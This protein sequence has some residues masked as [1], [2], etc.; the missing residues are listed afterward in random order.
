LN[1]LNL[2][3]NILDH[4]GLQEYVVNCISMDA[5]QSLYDDIETEGGS[6]FI[7]SRAIDVYKRRPLSKNTHYMLTSKEAKQLKDDSRIASIQNANLIRAS[8]RMASYTQTATFSKTPPSSPIT[9]DYKNWGLVRSI[10]G[11]KT[12]GWGDDASYTRT[13]TI[14]LNDTGKNV[15]VIIVDGISPVPNHPEFAK[16][17][18]GTGGT[19]YVQYDWY[20]LNSIVG[21]YPA[22]TSYYSYDDSY[23]PKSQLYKNH[24]THVAG[25]VAGNTNGWARDANIYQIS[26]YGFG[27]IDPLLIWDYIRAFH[28]NKTVNPLTGR[29]NP[30]ICNCSYEYTFTSEY[31][32]NGGFGKPIFAQ[33]RDVGIGELIVVDEIPQGIAGRELSQDEL[34]RLGIIN[35]PYSNYDVVPPEIGSP[36]FEFPF[37]NEEIAS[38]VTQ[39]LN[40]GIIIV[41]AAGNQS[42]FIDK[43]DGPDYNNTLYFGKVDEE[44][45]TVFFTAYIPYHKG[46]APSSVDGVI[47][48]GSV[49]ADSTEKIASYTNK[50]TGVDIFASGD[51]IISS[52]ATSTGI[53]DNGATVADS[54]NSSFYFGRNSGTSSAAAQVT[55]ILACLLEKNQSMTPSEALTIL[56]NKSANY[57]I[58]QD[59]NDVYYSDT[60]AS[61]TSPTYF[62]GRISNTNYLLGA[63]NKYLYNPSPRPITGELYPPGNYLLRSIPA[64]GILY[65]RTNIKIVT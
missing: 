19:R 2:P 9:S 10:E 29:K 53:D 44:N 61:N 48:V 3:D 32:L 25:I 34:Y 16:N 43:P 21:N 52:V 23:E 51:W 18:N 1:T 33:F 55:G 22:P 62:S 28:A 14:T 38:D 5:L 30:T 47:S 13:T 59:A 50:G 58:F 40:E 45:A 36:Y 20:Q 27:E 37:Y 4:E 49:S 64:T 12:S 31:L 63:K 15:D 35:T 42:F 54:R 11:A 56:N 17:A 6:G 7:P 46:S 24:G 60:P 26:P 65:P 39:A 8:I 57:Q 41:G